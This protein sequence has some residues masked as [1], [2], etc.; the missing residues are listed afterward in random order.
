MGEDTLIFFVA[1]GFIIMAFAVIWIRMPARKERI[2]P[3]SALPNTATNPEKF[4]TIAV[5]DNSTAANFYK[6]RLEAEGIDCFIEDEHIV[7]MYWFYW[8][9]VGG[10]KLKVKESDIQKVKEILYDKTTS[11]EP[12]SDEFPV[13]EG[14][15]CP[16]CNSTS[17]YYEKLN[18][19]LSFL[20]V[21]LV[22]IP[23]PIPKRKWQ[24]KSC[25]YEWKA[26]KTFLRQ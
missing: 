14:F 22:G 6:S 12:I 20:A 26:D 2:G 13:T 11:T 4:V 25:G 18:R 8:N 3:F 10:I 19:R 15:H 1:V 17:V 24:R 16:K 23:L 5:F 21:L 7:N 9:A